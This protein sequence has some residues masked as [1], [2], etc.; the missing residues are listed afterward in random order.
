[1]TDQIHGT[2]TS[3]NKHGCR[4][5]DCRAAH[6]VY[7]RQK[8]ENA[9]KRGFAGY[10]HGANAAYAAGCRCEK[11]RA[12]RAER[13]R[14]SAIDPTVAGDALQLVGLVRDYGP[15]LIDKLLDRWGPDHVRQVCVALAG[16]VDQD[17]TVQDLW[18]WAGRVTNL[19]RTTVATSKLWDLNGFR[20]ADTGASVADRPVDPV[21]RANRE[22]TRRKRAGQPATEITPAQLEAR[23]ESMARAREAKKQKRGAA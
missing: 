19:P 3:Y 1:M 5:D 10:T 11:C 20:A 14:P 16:A 4:C 23:R 15:D 13:D 2:E 22:L 17:R 12:Y 9:R 7:T 21:K 6:T 18:G 8:R